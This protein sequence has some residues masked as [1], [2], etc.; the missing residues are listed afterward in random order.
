MKST[1]VDPWKMHSEGSSCSASEED[2]SKFEGFE[3]SFVS[4]STDSSFDTKS[5]LPDS[6]EYLAS[7]E[8]KL[9]KLKSKR[10]GKDIIKSLEEKNKSSMMSF[11]AN[12]SQ[13]VLGDDDF[14]MDTPVNNNHPLMRYVAPD[15]QAL[16]VGELVELLKADHLTQVLEEHDSD[17]E[18]Q[19]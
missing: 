2:H 9:A 11:L 16:T 19:F 7:L 4:G 8:N 6:A 10:K 17:E 12:D 3:D 14:I 13:V 1:V 5:R 18:K 15:K